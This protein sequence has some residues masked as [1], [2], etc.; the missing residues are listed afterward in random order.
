MIVRQ[1]ACCGSSSVVTNGKF[2]PQNLRS[3]CRGIIFI[4]Y[5]TLRAS[6]V[7]IHLYSGQQ[8]SLHHTPFERL[9]SIFSEQVRHDSYPL[10]CSLNF[11]KSSIA[12]LRSGFVQFISCAMSV[13]N[14]H[15]EFYRVVLV[16]NSY[17][18][19]IP[20]PSFSFYGSIRP[21]RSA[22]PEPR[23]L[24][25][26]ITKFT[27]PLFIPILV[28]GNMKYFNFVLIMALMVCRSQRQSSQAVS[29]LRRA[30][31]SRGKAC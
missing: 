30:P 8:A 13:I 31:L 10:S 7:T 24:K 28:G 29:V 27:N 26:T 2:V 23:K 14:H 15:W 3:V 1:P 6:F 9:R 12:R 17:P 16:K 4:N 5:L 19:L 18:V 25:P 20:V 22:I 11:F 21:R